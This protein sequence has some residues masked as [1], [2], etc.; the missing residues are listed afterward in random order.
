M[1]ERMINMEF[2]KLVSINEA[3]DIIEKNITFKAAVE[4]VNILNALGRII[5]EDIYAN[6]NVPDFVRS[7]VDGYAIFSQDAFGASESL[8]AILNLV[9]EVKIGQVPSKDIIQ[10]EC[11][12]V[13]TGGMLP[14]GA[15]AVVMIEYTEKLDD[16]TILINKP[17]APLQNIVEIGEDVKKG[18]LIIKKGTKLRPYEIGVLSS[19]G[20]L[21]VDVYK[22]IKVGIIST[23]D[24][25]VD[26][27]EKITLG[28]VRDINSYLLYSLCLEE[29]VEPVLYGIVSDDY[30]KLKNKLKE[31]IDEC[32]V[33][34]M[35]GGSSVGN[36][37][38]TIKVINS[39]KDSNIFIHGISIKP[40]KPTIIGKI[41]EKFV[42]GLPGH[43]LA[44]AVI[45]KNF[46]SFYFNKIRSFEREEY[47]IE[48]IMAVNYHKAQGRAEFLPVR[49]K[50]EQ[51][52]LFAYPTYYKSGLISCF[53][54]SFGYIYIE[55]ELEGVY[56]GQTVK[57]Y[58]F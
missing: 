14:K 36:K 16:G 58:K 26:P 19:L 17:V 4:K 43:P 9:G 33:V 51:G 32:D 7:T 48:C 5:A 49:I 50:E 42:F 56:E 38:E 28:K 57:V 3:K 8:P 20:I 54:K 45:F 12:Y 11:M 47:P 21:E 29:G 37:D 6:E 31:A 24:E 23:G 1:Q 40:G 2:F 22:K 52:K 30:E 18:E 13:P 27:K 55:K 10:G 35:S 34:I 44:C 25:I 53:S 46:V 15:D 41:G 39:F